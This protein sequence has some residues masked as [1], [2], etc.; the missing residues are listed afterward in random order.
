MPQINI[1]SLTV[2]EV[3]ANCYLVENAETHELFLVDPGAEAERIISRIGGRKPVAVLLTHAHFD[4]IGAADMLCRRFGIPLYVHRDDASKLTDPMGNVSG[5]FG[6]PMTIETKPSVWLEGG[7]TLRLGGMEVEVLHTPGHSAGSVCYL[8]REEPCIF[9]GDTLFA[10]G[11]GRTDFPDGSFS[12]LR[13]SLR[14]LFSLMPRMI[15]YP[16]HDIPGFA[17]RDESEEA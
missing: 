8:M 1:E 9:T 4:H 10:N 5:L 7:E 3:A 12:Q 16:G 13:Q 6:M 11:Y 15:T 14:M 17:G 2:G